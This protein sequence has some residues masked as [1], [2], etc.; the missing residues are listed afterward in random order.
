MNIKE[1]NP[2]SSPQAAF[3]A[4]LRTLRVTRGW[5]QDEL[6]ERMGY[7][8]THV[9]GV[10]TGRKVP[11][12]PFARSA[13]R[14]L[15]TGDVFE[16][17]WREMRQGSLLEGF[18]EFVGYEGR[19][20]E[21]RLYE[22][23]VVPGL[24]QTREYATVLAESAV[25]RGAITPE[26]AAER[27]ALV[28]DRQA[29]LVR[30]LAPLIF[31]VLDESCLRRPIGGPAVMDAQLAHL[32]EFAELPNTVLQ[33]APFDM[34]ERRPFDLPVTVL[35]QPDRTLMSYAESAQRGYLERES[36]AVLPILTA[37]HQLQAEALS[38]AASVAM[39]STLRKGTP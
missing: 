25:R 7:S 14:A 30:R 3:G 9:S 11:T 16:R 1:L 33:V 36:T 13:D 21:I 20:A 32:V 10:E 6:G 34:G 37:Y 12:L 5:R 28:A 29:S 4:R 31:V 15:G 35:T 38:Q 23:G 18:P 39:I 2:E 17:E 24:L 22:V 19:A 27:I 26:Q 8:S